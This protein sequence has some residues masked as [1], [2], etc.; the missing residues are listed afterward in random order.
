MVSRLLLLFGVALA[1]CGGSETPPPPTYG[2]SGKVTEVTSSGAPLPGVTIQL[3]GAASSS[4]VTDAMGTFAFTGLAS[5]SYTVTP[6]RPGNTFSPA[7]AAVSVS[8][9][10]VTGQGFTAAALAPAFATQPADLTVTAG[11]DARFLVVVGGIPAPSLQWQVS[12]DGGGTWSNVLGANSA[13]LDVIAAAITDSG[14]R[15]RA[16]ASNVSGTVTSS[17]AVLT[18][19]AAPVAPVFTNQ[20]ASVTITAGQAT[21]FQV[22]VSGSPTPT[23][24]WQASSDGGTTWNDLPGATSAILPVTGAVVADSGRLYRVVATNVAGTVYSSTAT[25]TVNAAATGPVIPPSSGKIS[26]GP[27]HTCAIKADATVACWGHNSS[28]EVLPGNFSDQWTPVVVPGLTGMTKVAAGYQRSCAIDTAGVLSCWGGGKSAPATIKDG[29]NVAFTGTSAVVVAYTHACFIDSGSLVRC[30]GDNSVGQ[31]GQGAVST[32]YVAVPVIVKASGGLNLDRVVSLVAG[33]FQTCA[34]TTA[35]DVFC[36]GRGPIGDGTTSSLIAKVVGGLG[37]VSAIGSGSGHVCA[38]LAAGGVR[39]WGANGF[40]QLGNRNTVDQL[41]AVS[42]N[43]LAGLLLGVTVIDGETNNTCAIPASGRVVCWGAVAPAS[44]SGTNT[45]SPTEKGSLTTRVSNLS[46]GWSH[47]CALVAD[48]SVEC[49]GSNQ[50]GQ[51]GLGHLVAIN[52]GGPTP[53]STS[54]IGGAMFWK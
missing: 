53:P 44:L 16:V 49:W 22:T 26:V 11:H 42:V 2:I 12:L 19:T 40:G 24:Q 54:V 23:L 28:S 47:S 32:T 13:T 36:W 34:L 4:T 7:S 15:Y 35:G 38:V 51:L 52:T 27:F 41:L 17:V 1:A 39:C 5:G 20:P 29:S 31:L 9:A 45:Y 10:N 3:T 43:D 14:R 46:S 33:D 8:A 21:Q 18:V 37:G 25:L 50:F 48:G 6:S 30:W